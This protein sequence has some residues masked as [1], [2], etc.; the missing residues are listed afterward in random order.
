MGPK[1]LTNLL[2]KLRVRG[3]IALACAIPLIGMSAIAA[4]IVYEKTVVMSRQSSLI[5]LAG[6]A[7][8]MSDLVHEM[9]RERGASAVFVGS[10]GQRFAKEVDDQR[11]LTDQRRQAF[12]EAEKRVALGSFGAGFVERFQA[13]KAAIDQLDQKRR[14]IT[15][16]AIAAQDS[17]AYFTRT[18]VTVLE[19]V[20][21]L[22]VVASEVEVGVA[23][24]AYV[25]L[26]QGK[27]RAG[28]ERATGAA[29][30]AAGK[31]SLPFYV[32]YVQLQA[33]QDAYFRQFQV[34]GTPAQ[35][36]YLLAPWLARPSTTSCA[37]ASWA[38]KG[39]DR[40]I[41]RCRRAGLV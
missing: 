31:F 37:C 11:K 34:Y 33:E 41:G 38:S 32:R 40:H 24:A 17:N 19:V 1:F 36:E 2:G 9:Q 5:G 28:Q 15:G 23:V 16:L 8:A 30:F 29:E 21:E 14:E 35:R 13:A 6:L 25:N 18:N 22:S 3:R 26:L 10:K 27:E 12:V 4:N 20:S 7:G 39:A